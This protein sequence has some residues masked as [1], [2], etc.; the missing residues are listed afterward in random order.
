[1]NS[2]TRSIAALVGMNVYRVAYTAHTISSKRIEGRPF[3]ARTRTPTDKVVQREVKV[4]A[5]TPELAVVFVR[6]QTQHVV[7]VSAPVYL[8]RACALSQVC[9]KDYS[10]VVDGQLVG[11][12]RP[13]ARKAPRLGG[14]SRPHFGQW[15][16]CT[17][18]EATDGFV[19]HG[20]ADS[21]EEAAW[22]LPGAR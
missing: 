18:N 1:M 2:S 10:V 6:T 15:E 19:A 12:L 5:A 7:E 3:Y 9:G 13:V 14:R 20:C 16:A 21:R 11:Y 8:G 17:V 22:L 4:T